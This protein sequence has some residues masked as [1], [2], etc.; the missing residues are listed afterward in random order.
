[1]KKNKKLALH[2]ETLRRL[3]DSQASQAAGGL[4]TTACPTW[5][6]TDGSTCPTNHPVSCGGQSNRTVLW[7]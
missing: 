3:D 7:C 6:S 4:I 1:M 5:T 2:R